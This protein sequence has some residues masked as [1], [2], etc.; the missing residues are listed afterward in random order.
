MV[1]DDARSY[2]Q[3]RQIHGMHAT[4]A[5]SPIIAESFSTGSNPQ[6]D[7]DHTNGTH[8]TNGYSNGIS[9]EP[10][11]V[12]SGQKYALES[13]TVSSASKVFI[14]SSSD[15][16]GIKRTIEAYSEHLSA[17]SLSDENKYLDDLA[18]TL[19]EKRTMFP[20]KGF[21]VAA[22]LQEL[23][24]RLPDATR[25]AKHT[26]KGNVPKLGF[27]FTGQGAQW[28]A[29][30]RELLVYP[31]FRRSL[32]DA[33]AYLDELDSPWH[34]IGKFLIYNSSEMQRF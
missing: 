9:N 30:G 33:S 1:L 15:E 3:A 34:L 31:V 22:S 12:M 16:V 6:E 4:A 26:R 10:N 20:W 13:Q 23:L 27:V 32:E 24:K 29:M 7:R 25:R 14:F 2:L 18:Y 5:I 17:K 21:V 11:G 8:M 28:H 19:S